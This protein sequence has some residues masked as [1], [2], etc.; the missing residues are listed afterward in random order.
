MLTEIEFSIPVKEQMV[1]GDIFADQY[2]IIS[3]IGNGG[4]GRVF[5]AQHVLLKNVVALKILHRHMTV[6]SLNLK[7]FQI[8]AKAAS[9]LRH[10]N[11][12]T[13]TDYGITPGDQPYLIMDYLA[14]ESLDE[15][16]SK[17]RRLSVSEF[18]EVFTQ[19]AR[20]LTHAHERGI[21]H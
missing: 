7:R 17:H 2:R 11:L 21:V 18:L 3:E 20:G 13:V 14:G 9:N 19:V 5:K 12:V 15:F 1:V 10:E 4:M 8:E 6:D 16:L